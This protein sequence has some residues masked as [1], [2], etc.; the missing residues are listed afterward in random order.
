MIRSIVFL[1]LC[2]VSAAIYLSNGNVVELTP[3]NFDKMVIRSNKIWI[4]EFFVPWCGHCQNLVP[5]YVKAANA[6]KGIV[7]VAAVNADEYNE[8]SVRYGIKG[9]PTIKIFGNDKNKPEEYKGERTAKHI[10]DAGLKAATE[11]VKAMLEGKAPES[12]SEVIELTDD[13]FDKLVLNSKDMWLVEFIAPWCTHCRYLAPHFATAALELRGKVKLGALDATI[14]TMKSKEYGIDKYPTIKLFVPGAMATP[15]DYE[16]DRTSSAMINYVLGKLAEN[17]PIPD[18][19]QILNYTSFNDACVSK[20]L[21]IIA[22][23]PHILDCQSYCRQKYIDLMTAVAEKFKN[24][25]W[26]WVWS[27]AGAQ[28][29]LEKTLGVGGSGYPSMTV[30]CFKKMK[31]SILL[32]SFSKD[33]IY[34]FLRDLSFGKCNI[35]PLN[36]E[37]LLKVSTVEPWDGQDGVFPDK[38]NI[39]SHYIHD[40][41]DL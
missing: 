25:K 35:Y 18:I 4:V 28:T 39:Q 17:A 9:F 29:A 27:E 21:C 37:D 2:T 10:A 24:K 16:G 30:I 41:Y 38:A 11:K 15:E 5:E 13:N 34:E 8:L 7:S 22:F 23:L 36:V 32:G 26:G 33:G 3:S 20:P 1:I 19:T 14:N 31:Y 40:Q 12:T 6:L